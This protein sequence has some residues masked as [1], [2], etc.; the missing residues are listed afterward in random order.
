MKN[1]YKN[2]IYKVEECHH[3]DRK[4]KYAIVTSVGDYVS[5]CIIVNLQG[6][7]KPGIE[8]PVPIHNSQMTEISYQEINSIRPF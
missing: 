4:F 5:D 8:Q 6:D 3:C 7:R 1:I 2:G